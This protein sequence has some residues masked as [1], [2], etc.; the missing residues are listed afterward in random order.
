MSNK[1][2]L[3]YK[4][5]ATPFFPAC[6]LVSCYGDG[7]KR[8]L[9]NRLKSYPMLMVIDGEVGSWFFDEG[10]R[11]SAKAIFGRLFRSPGLMNKIR[12]RE[13][14]ISARLLKEIK[15]PVKTLFNGRVLT[16]KGGEK[17][18]VIFEMYGEYGEFVDGPGF[19]F[20][21][22]ETENFRKSIS[23]VFKGTQQEKEVKLNYLL[24]SYKLTNYEHFLFLLSE[25]I[26]DGKGNQREIKCLADKYYW[27]IH[28]YLGDVI[29]EKYIKKKITELRGGHGHLVKQYRDAMVRVKKI[30]EIKKSLTPVALAKV[31]LVQEMLYMYNERKKE[32]ANQVNIF[33][34]EVFLYKYPEISIKT[35]KQIFQAS[36]DELLQLL[37]EDFKIAHQ[38]SNIRKVY[39]VKD[40][41]IKRGSN[42]YFDLVSG[43]VRNNILKG[44]A[45][46]PGKIS[47][48][49]NMVLNV[50]HINKFKK[51]DILV[52]PFTN[53]NY[54]PIMGQARAILTETGGMTSHAAIISRELKIPSIVG[55][56][57]LLNSLRDGD[58]IEVDA[59]RGI[60]KVVKSN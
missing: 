44:L 15:T 26:K 29:D 56:K 53:V 57:N 45:A 14:E 39:L 36:P 22:Y 23:R 20:Q 33:I 35:L 60:V 30:K 7:F 43:C 13:R 5:S 17:L 52:A 31:N 48:R 34:K 27:L 19:L 9:G 25:I 12:R 8:L 59:D 40:G 55:I 6:L 50:S 47:G 11:R 37:R 18:K 51:G 28:D 4:T 38:D 41:I 3:V 32:V 21:V 24:T 46:S 10:L 1:F 54:L 49:V 42:K 58:I 2:H 16:D